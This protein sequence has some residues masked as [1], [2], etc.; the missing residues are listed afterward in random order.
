M[1][2]EGKGIEIFD[3]SLVDFLYAEDA[4]YRWRKLD[5]AETELRCWHDYRKDLEVDN[6]L[7]LMEG[8]FDIPKNLC[9][10]NNLNYH[11]HFSDGAGPFLIKT[12]KNQIFQSCY[13][14]RQ[15]LSQKYLSRVTFYENNAG[16]MEN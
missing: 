6:V 12:Y 14:Q 7:E 9:L 8:T 3:D 5:I 10:C 16:L 13:N 11:Y 2:L 1:F 15:A 4:K